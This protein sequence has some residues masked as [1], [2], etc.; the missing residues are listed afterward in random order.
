MTAWWAKVPWVWIVAAALGLRLTAA[1][2]LQSW[3]DRTPGRLCLIAGDAEGYWELGRK[4]AAG[5]EFAIYDPP[6]SVERMPGFPALLAIGIRFFGERPLAV[7]L[8]LAGVGSAACGLVYWLGRELFDERVGTMAGWLAAVSPTFIGFSVM[9]LSETL[10][11]AALLAS[12]IL[13]AR[14]CRADFQST[15]ETRQ[16]GELEIRPATQE[17]PLLLAA[18]A[19]A[20]CGLATLIRPTWLLVAPLFIGADFILTPRRRAAV[21]RAAVLLAGFGITMSP[22]VVRNWHVTGHFVPTTL[23]VGPSLYDSLNPRATGA[24]DMQFINWDQIYQRM[25][26]YDADRHYRQAAWAFV[27]E[28]P[29]RTLWLAAIKLGRFWNPLPNAEQFGHWAVAAGVAAFFVPV[30]FFALYGGWKLR[31]QPWLLLLTAGTIL[32]FSAIHTIFLGSL[33]YRLPAE[34]PLLPLAAAGFIV[35][36]N[37]KINWSARGSSK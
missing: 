14:L 16:T 27:R 21:A 18:A 1:V 37:S 36:R 7:R 31:G 4:L 8:I 32:Y 26:E 35:W 34:Y 6:R 9:L 20:L 29:G 17:R 2:V 19:G 28:N 5:K 3:L 33:R 30:V 15:L 13:L 10:F 23:W 12:L 11:A 22:W 24:S 25:S